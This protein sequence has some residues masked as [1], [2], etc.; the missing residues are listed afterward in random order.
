VPSALVIGSGPAAAGAALALS[1]RPDVEVTIL[2]LG[3][4]LEPDR[5]DSLDNLAAVRPTAWNPDEI[6]SLSTQPVDSSVRGLPEKRAYGSDYPFRDIGQLE[7][8]VATDGTHRSLVSAAYGGFSNVWG[9]QVMPFTA[10][11]FDTWPISSEQMRP[12]Y[13]AILDE[14]PFAAE[15]DDLAALFPLLGTPT[16]L[17]GLS[18]RSTLVLAAYE[19]H[20]AALNRLGV[21]VGRARLAFRAA[22]CVRCGL[23][24]TG[25]PY[26]LLYSTAQ[27]FDRLRQRTR[28][29]Y[30]GGLLALGVDDDGSG[31]TVSA[32]EIGSGRIQRF[33][34]DRVF[35]ACG[36]LGTTRLI[37]D[38]LR[39][40]ERPLTF[41]ESVQFTIPMLS[42]G[43]TDD[44]RR[45]D[46]FTLNQFNMLISLDE[47]GVDLSQLHFYTYNPAFLD[48]LP[49][50]LRT[51]SAE[52]A[53]T[54]L[55]RRLSVAIGYLPSWAA[56][57]L[58]IRVRPART[59]GELPDLIMSRPAPRWAANPMLRRVLLRLTRAGRLLDLWPVLPKMILAA[60]GKSYHFGGS[61]PHAADATEASS[62][63]VGRV[64]T[65][66]RVH[67]VDASVFPTVP[68]NTFT[69]TIMANAHRI[70][71]EALGL[72]W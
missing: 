14:I 46:Q 13:R 31:V 12:H 68:A 29:N 51:P 42:R 65:M 34:A 48:A 9:C 49:G 66:Q 24:M 11:T 38:S 17:P 41:G 67:L 58:D 63:R 5:Q 71:T 2:D 56:P 69:L 15:D 40:Y 60:G 16:P 72:P 47:A 59:A 27:T 4:R 26:S 44:P 61:F 52:R 64:S 57:R 55:I 53:R 21:T 19:A 43:A 20:R 18:Q 39:L 23:C 32:K 22:D 33:R 25:C 36:A 8:I 62:D 30:H 70:A 35:V 50:V 1:Q 7:H 54:M 45:A 28:L 37:A 6:R 10:A 3:L